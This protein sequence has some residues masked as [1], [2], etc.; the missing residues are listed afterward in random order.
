MTLPLLLK[1][2]PYNLFDGVTPSNA[3]TSLVYALPTKA[4]IIGIIASVASPGAATTVTATVQ[5]ANKVDGPWTTLGSTLVPDTAGAVKSATVA[6]SYSF[7]RAIL[8]AVTVDGA[9]FSLS[10]NPRVN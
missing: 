5:V 6:I 7:I 10:V 8:S 1:D 3:L 2:T 9:T 4:T